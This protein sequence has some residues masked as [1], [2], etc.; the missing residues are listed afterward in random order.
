MNKYV[1]RLL[2]SQSQKELMVILVYTSIIFLL[3]LSLFV[4]LSRGYYLRLDVEI[5]MLVLFIFGFYLFV[6]SKHPSKVEISVTFMTMVSEIILA[7]TVFKENYLNY[8]TVFPMLITF[9]IFYFY[10]LKA[11][12]WM[13]LGHYIF[14]GAIYLY[15]YIVYID[16]PLLHNATAML[17]LIVSYVFMTFMGFAYHISTS[18]Y[19]HQLE[20][21]NIQQGLLLKE[22]HH[23]VKN[24]LNIV[25]SMLGIQQMNE[26][27]VY[28]IEL[29]K[30]NR[31]RIESIAMIHEILYQ[32]EDF[33]KINLT[34]YLKQLFEAI[35]LM[36]CND[37]Q[38]TL[39]KKNIFLSLDTVLKLGVITNEL[40]LNSIKHAFQNGDGMIEINFLIKDQ[41]L[42]YYYRDSGRYMEK[43]K[44]AIWN[45]ANL[46]LKLI[47]MMLKQIYASI[48]I[49]SDKG[50]SYKI[51]VPL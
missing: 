34:D 10:R 20:E 18:S 42:I 39:P 43:N 23:R 7:I 44:E 37:I 3:I 2:K 11:A 33:S 22:I 31:L 26:E 47:K 28:I 19:Q 40:A 49:L 1:S 9:S 48:E 5:T 16:N 50:L 32:H 36:Y 14:W 25:S 41:T 46:G 17:G 27:D 21:A 4:N 38:V 6:Q 24:N 45:N 29:L 15:G 8:T 35:N 51:E 12:L 30:K 13:T